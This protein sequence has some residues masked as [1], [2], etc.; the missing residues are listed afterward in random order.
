MLKLKKD[1]RGFFGILMVFI[2]LFS[3]L[4]LGFVG[5]LVASILGYAS[6][7]ITPEMKNIGMVDNINVSQASTIALRPV[8][9]MVNAMPWLVAFAYVMAL[10]FSLVFASAYKYNP[11][12]AFIGIYLALILLLIVGAIIM[13]NVYEDLY[14]GND[15]IATRMQDQ[16]IMSYLLIYSPIILTIIAFVTGIY[17]FSSKDQMGAGV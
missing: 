14:N 12:P 9:S 6:S 2:I 3:I 11:N 13:S 16:A 4:I 17:M 5:V 10:I 7:V 15:E 8:E 1:K